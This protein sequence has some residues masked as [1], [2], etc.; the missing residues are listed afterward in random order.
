MQ[1]SNVL[2]TVT[3]LCATSA[4][5]RCF[6]GGARWLDRGDANRML[7]SVCKEFQGNYHPNQDWRVC[8]NGKL[9]Q[10][11]SFEVQNLYNS[12]HNL[13]HDD[14]VKFLAAEINNCDYGGVSEIIGFK[15]K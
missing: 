7:D 12:E 9:S 13:S 2:F 4:Y 15:F 14:C 6:K 8:R 3:A 5:A 10:R 1:L 11:Y